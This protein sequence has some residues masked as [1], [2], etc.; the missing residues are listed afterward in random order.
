MASGDELVDGHAAL[1]R[2]T[3]RARA[4][5]EAPP[6]EPHWL[7]EAETAAWVALAGMLVALPAALDAQLRRDAGIGHLE[8]QVLSWL[9]M[10]PDRAARMSVLAEMAA[11][12]QSRVSRIAARLERRGLLRRGADPDD[13]RGTLAE[14]TAAGWDA[15]VVAAPGHA[16]EVRRLVLGRLS[17]AQV[18]QLEQIARRVLGAVLPDRC[19]RVPAPPD[20]APVPGA[21]P[22]QAL[23]A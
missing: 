19:V 20:R 1:L 13:G 12:S 9:S 6:E 14:L 8:Y 10:T 21:G 23:P 16:A 4:R 15:V 17:A 22:D 5:R 11:V 18:G 3:S 7:D 2:L